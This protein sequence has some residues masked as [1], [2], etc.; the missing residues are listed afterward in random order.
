MPN[1]QQNTEQQRSWWQWVLLYPALLI[2]VLTAMPQW[3][4]TAKGVWTGQSPAEIRQLAMELEAQE[5]NTNLASAALKDNM[6]CL[7]APPNYYQNQDGINVDGTICEN[8]SVFLQFYRGD[9]IVF[10]LVQVP[11]VFNNQGEFSTSWDWGLVSAAFA[12]TAPIE[13]ARPAKAKIDQL[14]A[15]GET[16]VVCQKM[17]SDNLTILRHI[18]V[19][20]LCYDEHWNTGTGR[21]TRSSNI[22]CRTSC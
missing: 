1:N 8:G 13:Q 20:G 9:D 21:V 22:R 11:D 2:A 10:K 16:T 15:A 17:Q 12:N 3:M 5:L 19:N 7:A 4:E 6:G 18:K 14:F